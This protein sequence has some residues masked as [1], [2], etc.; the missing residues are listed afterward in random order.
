MKFKTT[1]VD[2]VL[3]FTII[4]AVE[5]LAARR[6][7]YLFEDSPFV[8]KDVWHLESG[9]IFTAGFR[10]TPDPERILGKVRGVHKVD[11]RTAQATRWHE[12]QLLD[13]AYHER[14]RQDGVD[15]NFSWVDER[16]GIFDDEGLM[17]TVLELDQVVATSRV[18]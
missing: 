13:D 12:Y 9:R 4:P 15:T 2:L 10:R 17:H 11:R 18:A 6:V 5:G 14:Y 7:Y 8:L 3:A 16:V 1:K